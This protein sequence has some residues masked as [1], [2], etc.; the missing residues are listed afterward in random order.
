M[1][2]QRIV[3][4]IDEDLKHKLRIWAA[5][6]DKTMKQVIEEAILLLLAQ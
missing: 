4:E 5:K 1:N 2:I 3:I 6:E